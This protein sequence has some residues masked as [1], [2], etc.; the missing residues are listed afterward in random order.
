MH[1]RDWA[2]VGTASALWVVVPLAI[3]LWRVTRSEVK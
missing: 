3:G 2:Q 1:A